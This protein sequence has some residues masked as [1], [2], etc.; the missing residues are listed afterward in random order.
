MALADKTIAELL[1]LPVQDRARA[2]NA[3]LDS[4]DEDPEPADAE[5]QRATELARRAQALADGTADV[6]DEDDVRR[7]IA[8][9]L[10]AVRK[11]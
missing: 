5:A 1:R 2:A 4:L 9:R 6:V 7:R 10:A 3:L 8:D 11:P